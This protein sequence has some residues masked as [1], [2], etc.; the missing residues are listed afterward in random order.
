MD[1]IINQ[2]DWGTVH[3]VDNV[4]NNPVSAINAEIEKAKQA[5]DQI[6]ILTFKSANQWVDEGLSMPDPKMYFHNLVAQYEITVLFASSNVGKSILAVQIADTV[7]REEKVAYIDLELNT[8][9]FEMRYY[10]PETHEKYKFP[11]NFDRAEIAKGAVPDGNLE[12]G[13]LSS[14]E[15][16]VRKGYRFF[17]I[18]NITYICG[19]SEKGSSASNFM[20]NLKRLRELY[21]LTIIVIAHTPKRRGY[22]PISQYDLA[23]SAVLINL[24]DAGF[25]IARSAKDPNIRY[26]KQVKVRTGEFLYDYDNVMVLEL[27]KEHGFLKFKNNGYADESDHLKVPGSDDDLGQIQEILRLQKDGQSIRKIAETLEISAG[28]VQRRLKKAEKMNITLEDKDDGVSGVSNVSDT[29]Q[30]IQ[31]IQ[32]IQQ[33][34]ISLPFNDEES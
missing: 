8:K 2:K 3:Q 22:E 20:I 30:P 4:L 12:N 24:F 13:I 25:A 14:V 19:D 10:D 28:M 1:P 18:D 9:Q 29:K 23:G 5:P 6:G 32:S 15:Q 27:V 34:D 7:A 33:P 17:I 21:S 31:A 26:L 16:S 11:N